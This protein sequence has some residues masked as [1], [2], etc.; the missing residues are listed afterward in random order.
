DFLSACGE[1]DGVLLCGH[2]P[3]SRFGWHWPLTPQHHIIHLA[4]HR[5]GYARLTNT[6]LSF[7]EVEKPRQ[8]QILTLPD[9]EF[10]FETQAKVSVPRNKP[11]IISLPR[12][13]SFKIMLTSLPGDSGIF[14][15]KREGI[16]SD[17]IEI[18]TSELNR[19]SSVMRLEKGRE[20]KI[21]WQDVPRLGSAARPHAANPHLNLTFADDGMLEIQ[22]LSENLPAFLISENLSGSPLAFE[23]GR[24]HLDSDPGY[25]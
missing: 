17:K 9:L 24:M 3:R 13:K 10:L 21:I 25:E 8:D 23:Q 22:N 12:G 5:T 20:P 16:L 19:P 14:A 11:I 18:T 1:P 2:N 6:E 7:I 4:S 15:V